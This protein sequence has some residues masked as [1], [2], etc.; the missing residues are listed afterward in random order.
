MKKLKFEFTCVEVP[1][2]PE[3]RFAYEAAWE[4]I[5]EILDRL[6]DEAE[7]TLG[8]EMTSSTDQGQNVTKNTVI[9]FS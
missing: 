5:F 1:L 3:K 6:V 9:E 8:E 4:I 7:Q 2:P